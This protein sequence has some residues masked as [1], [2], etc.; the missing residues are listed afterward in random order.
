MPQFYDDD[1]PTSDQ[2][3]TNTETAS[4]HLPTRTWIPLLVLT[5]FYY[6]ISCGI[7]RIYQPMVN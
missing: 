1:M 7:E 6:A 5:F 4:R 3:T 2:G